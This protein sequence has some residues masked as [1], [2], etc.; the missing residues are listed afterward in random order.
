[1]A[2]KRLLYAMSNFQE[3]I[4]RVSSF[5]V[6]ITFIFFSNLS[7]SQSSNTDNPNIDV[8]L[9][10]KD[11]TTWWD[12]TYFNIK[13][14]T[15]FI[16]LDISSNIISKESF[17]KQLST[18]EYIP[19]KIDG[20]ELKYRLF[21]LN[22]S[23]DPSIKT[24]V[25]QLGYKGYKN[26]KME[27]TEMPVFEFKD[28]KGNVYSN[29][30]IKGKIVVLKCWFV[31]CLPCV[32]EMPELNALVKEYRKRKDVLFISLASDSKEKLDSFLLT[33]KF[34]YAV[35][36]VPQTFMEGPLQVSAYPTHFI[37][38]KTGIIKKVVS[39]YHEMIST[40]NNELAK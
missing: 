11:F 37:I 15:E 27:G 18:G 23:N 20:T 17:L 26:Y 39:D 7:Y 21:K 1:M 10:Q 29:E 6:L 14:S 38:D 5:I 32:Q 35:L 9:V 3:Q 34:S 25:K 13:L 16:P 12:Y 28:I 33:H 31:N 30:S 36:P 2:T 4:K 40:L 8:N 24:E 22:P 19:L